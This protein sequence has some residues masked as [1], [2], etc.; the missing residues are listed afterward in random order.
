MFTNEMIIAEARY[1]LENK[2]TV[3]Q[4]AKEFSRGKTNVHKDMSLRLPYI[5]KGLAEEVA[6]V[7]AINKAERARRGGNATAR[8]RKWR[9]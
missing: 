9:N 8:K 1:L 5:H 6:E 4:V 2:A 3:R 7:L